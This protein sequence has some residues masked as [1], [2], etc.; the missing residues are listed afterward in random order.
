[1]NYDKDALFYLPYFLKIQAL[2][3]L[4][5]FYLSL[6]VFKSYLCREITKIPKYEPRF[7]STS[8]KKHC[9]SRDIIVPY[10]PINFLIRTVHKTSPRVSNTK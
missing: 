9:I 2:I 7:R 3:V 5:T 10:K 8:L 4:I 1:M 6:R